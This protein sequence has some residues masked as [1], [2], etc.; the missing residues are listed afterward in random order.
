VAVPVTTAPTADG[1]EALVLAERVMWLL[2][3]DEDGR[4]PMAKNPYWR[5]EAGAH[6]RH[7]LAPQSVHVIHDSAKRKAHNHAL[8][9]ECPAT[10]EP[11]CHRLAYKNEPIHGAIE[12]LMTSFYATKF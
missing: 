6:A 4:Y 8:R 5:R 7:G 12:T 11:D 3:N 10:F 9:M 1:K 2:L